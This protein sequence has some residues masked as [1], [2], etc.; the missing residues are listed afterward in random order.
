MRPLV[1]RIFSLKR[2]PDTSI[3]QSD[4]PSAAD[5]GDD[6]LLFPRMRKEYQNYYFYVAKILT[7]L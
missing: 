6:R 5:T 7:L 1:G 3:L 2:I 4:T